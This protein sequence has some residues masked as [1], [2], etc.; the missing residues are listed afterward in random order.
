MTQAVA[1]TASPYKPKRNAKGQLLPGYSG[2]PTGDA[3]R[4]RRLLN[5]DT[6]KELH[7]AFNRGGREAIDKVMK[8]NPAMFLKMLVLLVPRELQI[9]HSG[10]VKA[11]TDEQLETALAALKGLLEAREAKMVDVTPEPEKPKRKRP[12]K[13]ERGALFAPGRG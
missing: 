7:L 13:A 10:G 12:T 2:N 5:I 6:I 8:N 3:G 9:E 4:A 1:S 11:M